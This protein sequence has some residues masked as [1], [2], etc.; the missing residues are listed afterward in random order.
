MHG[1]AFQEGHRVQPLIEAEETYA[2]IETAIDRA[3]DEVLMAYWTLT[4]DLD[5]VTDRAENWEALLSRAVGRGVRFRVLL[6]DFDPVFTPTLHR[7]AWRTYRRLMDL[8]GPSNRAEATLQ[9]MC[10]QNPVRPGLPE[11]VA[12]NV[13]AQFR[14]GR[15]IER[16]AASAEEGGGGGDA[17]RRAFATAP[18]LWRHIVRRGDRFVRRQP[19][20]ANLLP[21]T[22]HEKLCIVDRRTAFVGGL[23]IG[24][25][26]YDTLR[27]D[28]ETPWHDLACRLEGPAVALLTH[29]FVDRWNVE[30]EA[31]RDFMDDLPDF[32]EKAD[33]RPAELRPMTDGAEAAG[34]TG[35]EGEVAVA[36][37]RSGGESPAAL[38]VDRRITSISAAIE[39]IVGAA[40]RFLYIETQYLRARSVTDRLIRAARENPELEIILLLPL[41]PDR[42]DPDA[43]WSTPTRHGH[44]LQYRNI[45]RL[46]RALGERV[47]V[48]TLVSRQPAG[49]DD[50]PEDTVLGARGIYVHAKTIV[51]D[52]RIA[53]VGSAN[54]NGRSL[55]LDTE[56]AIL[57]RQPAA[58]REFR[59]RLWHHH[60]GFAMPDDFDPARHSALALWN[61]AAAVNMRAGIT[62]RPGF[63]IALE[64]GRARRKARPSPFVRSRYV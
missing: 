56:A 29:H 30:L 4:P 27:H 59:Q 55:A 64:N 54:L 45:R 13:A 18:G 2:A 50:A 60:L 12:G 28:R 16:L 5:L 31:F 8:S 63:A 61:R 46:R 37:S 36:T 40:R 3:E 7:S 20:P 57:W 23:D 1:P 33:V 44:W 38:D 52:D 15:L 48:F 39:E 6:A 43:G 19:R 53:M 41:A 42:L 32:E 14:I 62:A 51:A 26:R 9:V 17:A 34:G 21:G 22:H 11:I 24:E 49:D 47:G 10:S 58:V 35:A 25:R